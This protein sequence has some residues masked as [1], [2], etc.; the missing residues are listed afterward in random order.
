VWATVFVAIV[1]A[2][3]IGLGLAIVGVPLVALVF[4]GR[5]SRRSAPCSPA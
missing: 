3:G 2:L 5:S 4:L 1:A